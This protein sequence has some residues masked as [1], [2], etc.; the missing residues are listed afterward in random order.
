LTT[1][2]IVKH[3]LGFEKESHATSNLFN[4]GSIKGLGTAAV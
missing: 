2:L 3:S 4:Q 1:S